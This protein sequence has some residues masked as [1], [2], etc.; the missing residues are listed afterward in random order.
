LKLNLKVEGIF[1][2]THMGDSSTEDE[3]HE[4]VSEKY[5]FLKF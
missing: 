4:K 2:P 1:K 5:I 3:Y